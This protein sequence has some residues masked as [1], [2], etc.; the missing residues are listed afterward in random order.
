MSETMSEKESSIAAEK[1]ADKPFLIGREPSFGAFF[2]GRRF[3]LL[4]HL[5]MRYYSRIR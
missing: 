2:N 3:L 4:T 1:N 5:S